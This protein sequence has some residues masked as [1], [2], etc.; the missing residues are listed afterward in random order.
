VSED[1]LDLIGARCPE[2]EARS[3]EKIDT[4]N[5]GD[6]LRILVDDKKS[7]ESIPM[8]V[9]GSNSKI[10]EFNRKESGGKEVFEFVVTK[11]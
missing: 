10:L 11:L 5:T 1:K 7:C 4:L 9:K 2:P 6:K 8:V 3:R